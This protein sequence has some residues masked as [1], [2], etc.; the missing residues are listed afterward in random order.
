MLRV[1]EIA[2]HFNASLVSTMIRCVRL[3]DFPCAVAGI[4]DG[5]VAWVFPSES[6]INAGI[7]PKKGTLPSNAREQFSNFQSGISELP[8][9]DGIVEE[10]FET[11]DRDDLD[12]VCLTEE[13]LPAR[14]LDTLLVL[15]TLDEGDVFAE[16]DDEHEEDDE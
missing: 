13:Y 8:A 4:R 7:Y 9:S 3:S 14:V 2:A 15:L 6:L 5:K 1:Q 11:Y 12:D 16:D 10:W